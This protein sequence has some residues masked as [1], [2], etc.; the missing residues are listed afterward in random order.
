MNSKKVI[1]TPRSYLSYSSWKL[2]RRNKQEW[3]N[4]YLMGHSRD[5]KGT[6][7]GKDFAKARELD[8][9]NGDSDGNF[10]RIFMP[11][12]PKRE[13]QMEATLTWKDLQQCTMHGK[14]DG[15]DPRKRLIADDKTT[16]STKGKAHVWTQKEVDELEQLTWYAYIFWKK[17]GTLPR[18]ELNWYNRNTNQ[19]KTFRTVRTVKDFLKLNVEIKKTWREILE[20]CDAFYAII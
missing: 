4:T 9:D 2:F 15:Y 1:E 7:F 13:H 11:K 12:Y 20:T 3:I 17:F 16:Y 6:Q 18:L 5:F 10:A 19:I 14:F 8:Q